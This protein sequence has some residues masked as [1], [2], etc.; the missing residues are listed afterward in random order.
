MDEV[1]TEFQKTQEKTPLA[2]YKYTDNIFLIWTR[3]KEHLE[4]FL[5]EFNNFN[6]DLKFTHESNEKE[7]P[8]FRF[9]G[10]VE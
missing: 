2:W 4:T 9:K 10:E 8:I 6:P 7:I 3:G 1:E 5:Q